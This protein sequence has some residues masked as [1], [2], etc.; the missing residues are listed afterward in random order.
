MSIFSQWNILITPFI[1]FGL[2]ALVSYL[3]YKLGDVMA[4]KLKDEGAKLC[5]Y[6][7]G[8]DFLGK[9]LQ[10]GYRQF[11]HAAL[12]FTMMHVAALVIATIPGGSLAFAILG[13]FYLMMIWFSIIALILK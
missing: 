2:F 3:I 13:I 5:Q 6:A 12:F 4:P 7:C 8:E 9:K 11:F 10:V 1:G